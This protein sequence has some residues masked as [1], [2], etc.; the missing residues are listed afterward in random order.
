MLGG[1]GARASDVPRLRTISVVE[2]GDCPPELGELDSEHW[3]T[4]A[5]LDAWLRSHGLST[6]SGTAGNFGPASRRKYAIETWL[7]A[8]GF[9]STTWPKGPLDWEKV[10][11]AGLRFGRWRAEA[12]QERLAHIVRGSNHD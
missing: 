3:T 2:S 12:I 10:T 5:S 11:R 1:I 8:N 4:A 7:R 6:A 9:V